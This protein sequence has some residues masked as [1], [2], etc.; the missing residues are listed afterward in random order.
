M[1]PWFSFSL[2]PKSMRHRSVASR[3]LPRFDHS[4][5]KVRLGD[6]PLPILWRSFR[7]ARSLP[8]S[9]HESLLQLGHSSD[10][11]L[12]WVLARM[13]IFVTALGLLLSI[14]PIS[15]CVNPARSRSSSGLR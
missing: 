2:L 10:S 4:E 15:R 3:E 5:L 11:L 7:S 8:A 9:D 14:S 1:C 12:S 13:I 6:A